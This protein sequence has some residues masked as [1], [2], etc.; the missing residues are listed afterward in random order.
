MIGS[1]ET[2]MTT[3]TV[4]A[5]SDDGRLEAVIDDF[6]GSPRGRYWAR[7][8]KRHDGGRTSYLKRFDDKEGARAWLTA[9]FDELTA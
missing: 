4:V 9:K 1:V 3:R 5:M 6:P 8:I 7:V 2:A